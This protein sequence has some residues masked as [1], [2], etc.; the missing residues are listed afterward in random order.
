[1]ALAARKHGHWFQ[2]IW[3]MVMAA[4]VMWKG[5][6]AGEVWHDGYTDFHSSG[7]CDEKTGLEK[8]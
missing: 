6:M 8:L 2:W 1:M 3:D 4:G 7:L 5:F